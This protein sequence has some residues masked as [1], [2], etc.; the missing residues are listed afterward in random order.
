MVHTT[1]PRAWC[2]EARRLHTVSFEEMLEMAS[3]HPSCRSARLSMAGTATAR[4]VQLHPW[5]IP[6]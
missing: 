2:S 1:G 3:M 4:A 5:D 6:D